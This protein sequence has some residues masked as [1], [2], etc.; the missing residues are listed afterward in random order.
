MKYEEKV[1]KA[2][3]IRS[4]DRFGAMTQEEVSALPGTEKE[5]VLGTAGQ[6]I[7]YFEIRPE[8]E[9]P[10]P[11]PLIINFH[12]GGFIKGRSDRDR[13]YCSFLANE[14]GCLVWDV[15]Y[16]LAPENP[17]P[18][19]VMECYNITDYAFQHAAGLKIDPQRIALAGHS[20]GGNFAAAV[21]ILAA[22]QR[23]FVPCCMLM[24]YFPA[25][26]QLKAVDKLS[27]EL[28]ADEWWVKRAEREQEYVSFYCT[29]G[30]T[31]DPLCSP[32]LAE[33]EALAMFP[34]SLIISAGKDTLQKETEEFA[35]TLVQQGVTVL[36]KRIPEA[37][38]GFTT[39]RTDGWQRA[40]ALHKT[41]FRQHF[42]GCKEE[43]F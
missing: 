39:N 1:N 26:Q 22:R 10:E 8:R 29:P 16:T 37:M 30:E 4:T 20:A 18:A 23:S 31:A 41:F 19:G 13:R 2:N 35:H 3:L 24:E 43:T 25:N 17:F 5:C 12:G 9:L 33:P 40:L 21:M 11:C 36:Q 14:L 28:A 38:H 34:D 7:R 6:R 32:I 42:Y 15:D 27:P